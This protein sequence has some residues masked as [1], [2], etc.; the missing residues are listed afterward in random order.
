M[1][2]T[3]KIILDNT[4]YKKMIEEIEAFKLMKKKRSLSSMKFNKKYSELTDEQKE[5]RKL[6]NMNAY[7][8]KMTSDEERQKIRDRAREYY[9]KKIKT[10]TEKYNKIKE[11]QK[12]KYH[13]HKHEKKEPPREFVNLE[14]AAY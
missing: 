5:K 3:D 11:S 12:I 14:I 9:Q 1:L 6:N 2:I 13:Q 4:E 8:K 7:Y 10:D